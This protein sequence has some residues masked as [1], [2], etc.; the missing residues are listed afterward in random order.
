[1]F[2]SKSLSSRV[3]FSAIPVT[4]MR[5]LPLV[6]QYNKQD[7]PA[8]LVMSHDELDE[9]LNFRGVRSFSAD[10]LHGSGVFE[11]LKGVSEL[12]LKKLAAGEEALR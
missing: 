7:L 9:A 12:V 1:M 5:T 4:L 11:T 8:D 3:G 6:Y 2:G 10:C